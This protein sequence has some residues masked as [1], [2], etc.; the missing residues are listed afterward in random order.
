M[1]I[2]GA[3]GTFGSARG[4]WHECSSLARVTVLRMP[5]LYEEEFQVLLDVTLSGERKFNQATGYMISPGGTK[6]GV[7]DYLTYRPRAGEGVVP[8]LS[9]PR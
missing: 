2:G 7:Q 9:L 1:I 6:V 5:H 8:L 4:L 3:K